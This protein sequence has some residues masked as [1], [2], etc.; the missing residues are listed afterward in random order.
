MIDILKHSS[1]LEITLISIVLN[2]ILLLFSVFLYQF[3]SRFFVKLRFR[4]EE[5]PIYKKDIFLAGLVLICNVVIFVLGV[6][7]W[8]ENIIQLHLNASILEIVLKSLLLLICMDFLMYFFHRIVHSKQ[9]FSLVHKRHHEHDATN[10]ISLFVLN[11]LEA[12]GFGFLIL[13]VLFVFDFP[14][15][16]VVIY[17]SANL[18]WGTIGHLNVEL[19]PKKYLDKFLIKSLGMAEF[20][21]LHHQHIDSN[22]GFYTLIWDQL[23]GTL[24]T[25]YLK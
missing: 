18:L 12:L 4:N 3:L 21:N 8:R 7:L 23:F 9:L 20:H 14:P 10:A 11:P 5:H 22:F 15:E 17:L 19:L 25:K 24:D 13:M 16:S 6:F 1:Y 2:T